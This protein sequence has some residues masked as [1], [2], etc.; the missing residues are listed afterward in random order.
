MGPGGTFP[1]SGAESKYNESEPSWKVNL[2]WTVSDNAMIYASVGR[3]FKSTL[4]DGTMQLNGAIFHYNYKDW[5]GTLTTVALDEGGA[6]FA[7]LSNIGDVKTNGAELEW[8]WLAAE[9]LDLRRSALTPFL[10]VLRMNLV[11]S[12]IRLVTKSHRRP[13]SRPLMVPGTS[14][15]GAGT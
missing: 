11:N 14:P 15:Y 7:G 5:Q 1:F 10:W 9:G 4:A 3:G 13:I 12:S 2:D 6:Q 8:R